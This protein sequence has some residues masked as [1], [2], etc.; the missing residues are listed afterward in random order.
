MSPRAL[1]AH[2]RVERAPGLANRAG[3]KRHQRDRQIGR[4]GHFDRRIV[5][6]Y[7]WR[8][9][10]VDL[11]SRAEIGQEKR[12]RTRAALVAAAKSLFSS[13]SIESVTIDEIV[14]EAGLAKGTFYTHFEDLDALTAA[15]ADELVAAFDDLMQPTRL[16]IA[17]PFD[18]VAFGCNA[19]IEKAVEDPAWAQVVARMARFHPAVGEGTRRHLL[20]DLRRAL[21]DI[22]GPAPSLELALE[23]VVGL[24][25][26]A[27]SAFAEKRVSRDDRE[28]VLVALLR[29][30]GAD[31]RRIRSTMARMSKPPPALEAQRA[32]RRQ[33]ALETGGHPRSAA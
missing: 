22:G 20:E 18:R 5:T 32:P 27:L 9:A 33:G 1:P 10:K 25:L 29:A 6:L 11:A 4:I 30:L 17:D 28:P 3:L 14:A 15:I 23:I 21:K 31:S 19:F 7:T 13:R 8:M 2:T 12:A 16:A 26:Q 24:M